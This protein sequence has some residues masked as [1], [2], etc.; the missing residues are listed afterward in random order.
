MHQ[1][2]ALPLRFFPA[3]MQAFPRFSALHQRP[4]GIL[5]QVLYFVAIHTLPIFLSPYT[6]SQKNKLNQFHKM[7]IDQVY[8]EAKGYRL[9]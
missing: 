5:L 2:L 6:M 1:P 3:Y 8:D 9:Q 4:S 7:L